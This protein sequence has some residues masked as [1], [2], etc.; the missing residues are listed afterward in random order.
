MLGQ[1]VRHLLYR[2]QG[3]VKEIISATDKSGP[4]GWL[5]TPFSVV[6]LSS[7]TTAG[8]NDRSIFLHFLGHQFLT[9]SSV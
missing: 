9:S 6:P 4:V 3:R 8:Q 7:A 2:C 5:A 1:Q